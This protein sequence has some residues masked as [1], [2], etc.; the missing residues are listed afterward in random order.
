MEFHKNLDLTCR[1]RDLERRDLY[2]ALNESGDPRLA[3]SRATVGRW[4][5]GRSEPTLSQGVFVARLLETSVE[6]LFGGQRGVG[7]TK[8]RDDASLSEQERTPVVL[9][10]YMG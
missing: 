6:S 4:F 9:A 8:A 10:R 7:R 2:K 3:V 5:T 1:A